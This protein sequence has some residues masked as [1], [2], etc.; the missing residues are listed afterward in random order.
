MEGE[1][2]YVCL[3]CANNNL[4]MLW[5]GGGAAGRH[6]ESRAT[7]QSASPSASARPPVCD[8]HL[9]ALCLSVGGVP[10]AFAALLAPHVIPGRPAGLPPNTPYIP[11]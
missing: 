6:D 4:M 3:L 2:T 10:T 5:L 11:D 8:G 9:T 1:A 7:G